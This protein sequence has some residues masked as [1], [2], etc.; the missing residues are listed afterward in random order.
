MKIGI[1]GGSFD[2]V[3]NEHISVCKAA[4]E[5]LKTDLL[6]VVPTHLAP[7]KQGVKPTADRLRF[8]MCQAAFSSL[9][10]VV[11]SDPVFPGKRAST[12]EK[13]GK[14]F[15]FERAHF[16]VHS[17]GASEPHIASCNSS[18]VTFKGNTS[19]DSIQSFVS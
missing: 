8:A 7:H 3:H 13:L 2:P 5:S 18:N 16:D 9:E 11:L 19:V 6:F 1:F 10:G 12:V 17:F 15:A 4:K 14:A